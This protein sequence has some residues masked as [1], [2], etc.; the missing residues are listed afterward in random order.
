MLN[1]EIN[2]HILKSKLSIIKW[3][4]K[5]LVIII[6]VL[7][8]HIFSQNNSN[9]LDNNITNLSPNYYCKQNKDKNYWLAATEVVGLNILIWSNSKYISKRDWAD[10]SISSIK[11]NI[12][13]GFTWDSDSFIMNQFLHP[14]HGSLYFNAA[15]S[16][17]LTFWESAPF[18]LGGSLMWEY[19]MEIERPSYNDLLNT[20]ISGII[21]GE[22][23]HRVSDLIIDESSNG[24]ER[25]SRE[26]IASII[27]PMKGLNRL[28]KGKMWNDGKKTNKPKTQIQIS[29]GGNS[30]FVER[31]L[32]RN[33]IYFFSKFDMDYGN[34][35]ST[36]KHKSPF[37]YFKISGEFSYSSHDKIIGISGSGVLWDSKFEAF[38]IQNS[39]AGLYKEFILYSNY[40]FKFTA[41]SLSG[42]VNSKFNFSSNSS[43]INSVGLSGIFVGATNSTYSKLIGKDYNL[44]PGLGIKV[45]SN[46][47]FFQKLY[48][49]F[50]YQQFWIH[51]MNGIDGDEF[52]SMFNLGLSYK[53]SKSL[54][55]GTNIILYERFGNYSEFQKVHISNVSLRAYTKLYL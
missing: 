51:I 55:L 5:K 28:V 53:I 19:M 13:Y 18:A 49:N 54:S 7:P 29:L 37:D 15:R 30:L 12:Q 33:S 47:N 42:E 25:F 24:F 22:I 27:N 43:V 17:G 38:S 44:G 11:N 40:V 41:T 9:I 6:L 39:I 23:T 52:I 8:I 35:F 48:L 10:I 16:N 46:L 3:I 31:K 4:K 2:S 36:T 14:F 34:K 45:S 50:I 1:S 32:T 26:F 21:L 20:T